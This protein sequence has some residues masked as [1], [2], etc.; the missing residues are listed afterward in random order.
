[1]G[2][3]LTRGGS[4][5]LWATNTLCALLQPSPDTQML[6]AAEEGIIPDKGL[7]DEKLQAEM[8]LDCTSLATLDKQVL[9]A[10]EEG[11]IPD[12]GL[13]DEKLQ[14]EMGLDRNSLARNMSVRDRGGREFLHAVESTRSIK[15]LS[16]FPDLGSWVQ[17][18]A[19]LVRCYIM[20]L[21]LQHCRSVAHC[22]CDLHPPAHFMQ[23]RL[24]LCFVRSHVEPRLQNHGQLHSHPPHTARGTQHQP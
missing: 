22:T 12:K 7:P 23:L 21:A 4:N 9:F 17:G 5:V 10:A 19:A 13:P 3:L 8:G 15:V 16:V 11:I 18:S 6:F 20:P 1:M 24:L 14:A 2:S